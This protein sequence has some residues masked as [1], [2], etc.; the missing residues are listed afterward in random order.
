MTSR[1]VKFFSHRGSN[2]LAPE[3]SKAAFDHALSLSLYGFETDI[4]LT[5]DGVPVLWHDDFMDRAARP[6][7]QIHNICWSE[8]Q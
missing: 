6:D 7:L 1:T 2:R 5:S 8:L 4:Q 3:N